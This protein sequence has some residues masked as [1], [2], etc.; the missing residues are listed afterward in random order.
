MR[1]HAHVDVTEA[2]GYLGHAGQEIGEDL[3]ARLARAVSLVNAIAAQ[4]MVR[5][6]PIASFDADEEGRPC[7]VR[8]EGTSFALEGRDIAHHLE[9]A[10]EAALMVVTLGLS[11]ESL[12]RREATL[13]PTDGL[14]VDACAS[15]LVESA[16]NELSRLVEERAHERGMRSG[17]RFSPGYGDFPLS[18]QRAFLDAVGAGKALGVSVT[19]GDLLVPSKSITAVSGLYAV[20]GADEAVRTGAPAEGEAGVVDLGSVLDPSPDPSPVP[21]P[22]RRRCE[23]CTLAG[24]CI[25]RAQGR[26][27]YGG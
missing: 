5:T 9:G 10:C 26:T 12:L 23:T 25:L 27:C 7:A 3:A 2:L 13:N 8:L 24:S 20:R 4:G 15:S 17:S 6:F 1:L 19:R 22:S 18:A 21:P 11:S 16:A 14:L